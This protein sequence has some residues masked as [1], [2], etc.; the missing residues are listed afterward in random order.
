[1]RKTYLFLAATLAF[2][3]SFLMP[4]Q[5]LQAQ[6]IW[7]GTADISWYDASQNTFDIS[8]PEQLAGVAQLVNSGTTTF[9]GKTLNMT[10]DIW[11]NSTGDSTN[12]WVPI[13]GGSPSSEST[14]T[15]NAFRGA[16]N[17]H[18]H[19]IYNLYC[20]KGNTFHGGLI[21]CVQSPCTI[22][23]LVM[24]NPVVKSRG[25]MGAIAGFTR[26]SGNV[27][28]RY[29]LVVNARLEA[30][31]NTDAT[32]NNNSACIIGAAYNN[33]SSYYTYIQNCGATGSITGY[34][35]SGICASG[36]HS[37]LQNCYFAGT[38]NDR[39]SNHGAMSA[40]GA[41]VNNCYS[42]C[43]VSASSGASNGTE[44]SQAYMQSD[45]IITDLGDAFKMDNG[46]NNGYPVMSYM[47]GVDPI[48]VSI[49]SGESVTITAFG[50]DSYQWST[51]ATTASITVSPTTT[52]TYTVTGT[53]NGT[54]FT[55]TSTVTVFPQAVITASVVPSDDSQVHATVTPDQTTIGCGSTGTV[56]FTVTPDANYRVSRVTLNGTEIF[57]DVFGEGTATI[58][59]DPNGTLGE[60]KIYLSNTYTISTLILTDLGDTLHFNNL[61]QPY[62]NNGINT[63]NAGSNVHYDFNNTARWHLTGAIVDGIFVTDNSYDFNDI[64]ENHTIEATYVD[65]CGIASIPFSEDFE[66]AT[67]SSVPECYE[68][69]T[70]NTYPYAYSYSSYAH[71]GSN[72]IYFY[73]YTASTEQ[74]FILPKVLD[75]N[76]Y[77]LSSLMVTFYARMSNASN[78]ITVG[79]M[80]DPTDASTFRASQTFTNNT[81]NSQEEHVVYLGNAARGEYIAFKG[82]I[83]SSYTSI[84][85][86]DIL[87]ELAP[88]CSPVENLQ[89]SDVY[90]TNATLSWSPNQVGEAS[91]Y[92]IYVEDLIAGTDITYT[93]TT[94]SY[95]I[96]GLSELTQYRVG[97]FVDCIDNSSSDTTFLTFMTPCNS[98]IDLTV[99]NGTSTSNY[100]PTNIYY[101]N[102]YSQQIITAAELENTAVDFSALAVQ[103]TASTADSRNIDI[104]LSNIPDSINLSSS[105]ILPSTHN[106]EFK[107]V[108][109]GMINFNNSA[110][111]NWV[112][113]QF[114]TMFNYNGT[115]NMLVVF[116]DHTNTYTSSRAFRTHSTSSGM[117]RYNYRDN[118]P[119]DPF[120]PN[121]N[122]TSYAQVNNFKFLSCDNSSC[123]RPNTVSASNITSTS[124]DINWVNPNTT[125]DCEIEYKADNDTIWNSVTSTSGSTTTLTGLDIN[126]LYNVRVRAICDA[127]ETSLWSSVLDFRTECDDIINLPYTENFDNSAYG[128]GDDAYIYCWDRYTNTPSKP[129]YLYPTS[130][131][132]STPN[133]LR[134]YDGAGVT[135][136]AIMPK[137]D[138]SIGINTL[139]VSF[140]ARKTSSTPASPAIFEIGVMTDKTDPTSF[141]IMD[142][143]DLPISDNY[144]LF[145]YSL[146]NYTGF[147]QYI[148]FRVSNGNGSNNVRLDDVVLDYIP[149]C[150]HPVNLQI[151]S[152]GSDFIDIHWTE[153]GGASSWV[154]EYGP[155]GFTPGTGGTALTSTDTFFT[156]S[157]LDANTVYDIYVLSDCGGGLISTQ[158]SN[159]ARTDCGPITVPYTENFESGIYDTGVDNQSGQRD[160][161]VC[162]DRYA[163]DHS[164][165]VYIP[166]S[167]T[168]SHSGSH[169]LDFHWTDN[170]FNIAISPEF[171]QS[172][173]VSTLMANFWA[174]RTGSSGTL[175]VGV[176]T[177][178][179][180]ATTFFPIDTIDLSA[181]NT[182][183]Y[184]EQFVQFNNYTGN[185]KYIAFRVSN[186]SSCGFYIDDVTIDIAPDCSPVNNLEV[187]NITGTSAE[188][189]W[190]AG[191]FGTTT[192]Y[193]LEYSEGGQNNWTTVNN[194]SGNTYLLG[195]LNF[196]TYYD[197]R[198]RPNCDNSATGDWT[199]IT[200]HTN[201]LVGGDFTI[202]DGTS[203]NSFLPSYSYYNYSY[204]QQIFLASEIGT[205]RTIESVTLDMA[206]F[207]TSRS[208]KIY[209][210]HTTESTSANWIPATSAQLVYSGSPT[211]HT[212]LNTFQ[213]STP[214]NYNGTDNLAMIIL[215]ETGTYSSGNTWR[216]HTAPFQASRYIYNDNNPY[217]T[218]S[219][220]TSGT[221]TTSRNNV[222]FGS[223]CDTTTTCVAPHTNV[224]NV[225]AN[226]ADINWVAGYQET[227]WEIEYKTASDTVWN[228][229]GSVT[230][231]PAT[232]TN[233][234]S[235][236]VYNYRM[237]SDCGGGEY[238]YWTGGT[239]TTDCDAITVTSSTP[240]F[241]DFESYTGT[242]ELPFRCWATPITDTYYHGPFVYGTHGESCHSGVYSAE[243]KGGTNMMVLPE[244]T[245]DIHELR[246]SFW[247]TS[248]NP[249]TGT[250]EVGVITNIDN[251]NSF[252]LLSDAGRPG[253]RG[254]A[255]AGNGNYMGPF[256]FNSVT[257][258]TGRIALRYTNT[259]ASQSW[260]LDDFT[261]EIAPQ[262]P[263]PVKNSVTASNIS[264]IAAD[265][266]WI[267]NDP[268]HNSWTVYYTP[269]NSSA[270]QSVIANT[271][272]VTLSGLTAN[273]SYDVYVV[274]NCAV[275]DPN[276]DATF[277]YTFTTASGTTPT[278]C[279]APANITFANI[280]QTGAVANWTAGGDETQWNVQ[281]M[282]VGG[283][284]SSSIL[285]NAPTYTFTGLS[286]NTIYLVRVQAVCSSDVSDWSMTASFTTLAEG[287]ETCYAPT[288]LTATNITDG[289]VTLDWSQQG[290]PDSWTINYKKTSAST[291]SNMNATSHPYT[292]NNLEAGAEYEVYVVAN[293]GAQH[294]GE[295][296][297][298]TFTAVGIEDYLFSSTALFPNPTTGEFRI[299][300]SKFS[301]QSVEVF[302]VFG[303]LMSSVDVN[304]NTVTIDATSYASGV[305]FVRILTEKG[306]VTKRIVKK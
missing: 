154:V 51:G 72:T 260:N 225:T 127:N 176:M 40:W 35:V 126:T 59:V 24:I 224:S 26:T 91:L 120:N 184:A 304:D 199:T 243:M 205:P 81:T 123:I 285:V 29:C 4:I 192:D 87:V 90:G 111:D 43:N 215:D 174:C 9:E 195:G 180:D 114:D 167:T 3:L 107:L 94:T 230:A 221:S 56:Q 89:I 6:T 88:T 272:S 265:I 16:F 23:S 84:Y 234:T 177:D 14:G 170:C 203:T 11:L 193:T 55:H 291:W 8:T 212:G 276:P 266:S 130:A 48:E 222:I 216:T 236:T 186:A 106:I 157:N 151:D 217:S 282:S 21:G 244:F 75:T 54:S 60:V 200:F 62:G 148:A 248:T 17:G 146:A 284:W 46:I 259:S 70:P 110:P 209:L 159:S 275:Q 247:A 121:V 33:T 108:Y 25:M 145:E 267:D 71:S 80:T 302:D 226:S 301:I 303:K 76:N 271:Q 53:S 31:A 185:G 270:W 96:L 256:D 220:P 283:N 104:Y 208:Y 82:F 112:E 28:I 45:S 173:D 102:S 136:I 113:I 238:S 132:H 58:T 250:L 289:S 233:L 263:S 168:Y 290:T 191:H 10:T 261:V 61:V 116:N 242:G 241:E 115:D 201:C 98:P 30:P 213:F 268:S 178:K 246:L 131:A 281:Y 288:A 189:S 63:V 298:V 182:Y 36:E 27:Y 137:V 109:S 294:S 287:Q 211:L 57:G 235:N 73:S 255:S 135:N 37:N 101:G 293:C 42:Y 252:E 228:S 286:S 229:F 305:Y 198:V 118:T 44:V 103:Y 32:S 68:R 202:G 190:S 262:C 69:I 163:S 41:S 277:T 39:G 153:V 129:V 149:T 13:G 155:Q 254:S 196:S 237:R 156:I 19:T 253:E 15:G 206:A 161:I 12:N 125:Q 223:P 164:H 93:S 188:V 133:A 306:M 22:D 181:S 141:E 162:W 122:G 99:G 280:S 66:S 158:I 169:Y 232:L 5:H 187:N 92:N 95:T 100:I 210:M 165:N 1:M 251:P 245:N 171:D 128:S 166:N 274:T 20:D 147:G 194:I 264:D 299:Q 142:T 172:I 49:C 64:H 77:P 139:Q 97:V 292:L 300:N 249:S 83:G 183:A 2:A 124:A 295:S 227:A 7:D 150:Q 50:Y 105:W 79:T 143:I 258:T 257:A 18:G 74:Y 140:Y 269:S 297:H 179:N 152:V 85:L 219:T 175:E 65:S 197:L 207:S 67:S 119:Y 239:F 134:F 52:T 279:N 34:Y 204:S 144:S 218:S 78:S 38:L 47:A 273:T 117:A 86:D 296:N 231:S 160:Y 214:F 240:W 138:A 278:Q